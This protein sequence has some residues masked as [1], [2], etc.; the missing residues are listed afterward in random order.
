MLHRILSSS[1]AVLGAALIVGI[2]VFPNAANLWIS[3][4]IAILLTATAS[5]FAAYAFVK[6]HV[7]AGSLQV[8]TAVL[9]VVLIV[10]TILWDGV[11]RGWLVAVAG[12]VVELAAFASYTAQRADAAVT[13]LPEARAA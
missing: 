11:S 3:F 12:A 8:A 2:S 6:R 7:A 10:A 5:G 13:R 1:S 4:A 9:G